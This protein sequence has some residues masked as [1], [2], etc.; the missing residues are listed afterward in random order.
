MKRTWNVQH[1]TIRKWFDFWEWCQV[2]SGFWNFL[3]NSFAMWETGLTAIG[4][5]V[6]QEYKVLRCYTNCAVVGGLQSIS[7]SAIVSESVSPRKLL[8]LKIFGFHFMLIKVLYLGSVVVL[9]FS[10]N[11]MGFK[12]T[13]VVL[14]S[15]EMD[16]S[17][18]EWL[19]L[20]HNF[21]KTVL[22]FGASII[23]VYFVDCQLLSQFSTNFKECQSLFHSTIGV[24]W[25]LTSNLALGLFFFVFS[26]Y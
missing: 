15:L 11:P 8:E 23:V 24:L 16:L 4:A 6:C 13:V 18:W 1:G 26:H 7:I 12:H 22:W 10:H 3:K 5:T 20:L 9:K 2:P 25:K 19:L 21:V 17:P 14:R